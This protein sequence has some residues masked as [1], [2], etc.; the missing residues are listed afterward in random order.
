MSHAPLSRRGDGPD[1]A[2]SG[3]GSTGIHI[4]AGRSQSG[5]RRPER[6]ETLR[7]INSRSC[8]GTGAWKRRSDSP[9]SGQTVDLGQFRQ[10]IDRT[11]RAGLVCSARGR[12]QHAHWSRNRRCHRDNADRGIRCL[13]RQFRPRPSGPLRATGSTEAA[14]ATGGAFGSTWATCATE[15]AIRCHVCTSS[16]PVGQFPRRDAGSRTRRPRGLR[17]PWQGRSEQRR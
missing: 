9:R 15:S 10:P 6:S 4:V 14:C 8:F 17:N 16:R 13:R 1:R 5:F 12:G 2:I 7:R 11:D 3:S